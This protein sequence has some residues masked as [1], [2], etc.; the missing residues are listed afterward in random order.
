MADDDFDLDAMLDSALDE[1][2]AEPAGDKPGGGDDG[3]IDLDAMLDEAMV[4][5]VLDD[6][7]GGAAAEKSRYK[8]IRQEHL[9]S[10]CSV[11]QTVAYRVDRTWV[12]SRHDTTGCVSLL[13]PRLGLDSTSSQQKA[14]ILH[15]HPTSTFHVACGAT[16]VY[17]QVAHGR[18]RGTTE[19]VHGGSKYQEVLCVRVIHGVARQCAHSSDFAKCYTSAVEVVSVRSQHGWGT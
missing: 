15:Q 13:H 2:F 7:D 17:V 6:A 5:S 12:H 8:Y 11:L 14:R 3:D 9:P 4:A 19:I 1:G 18:S 16:A 10:L